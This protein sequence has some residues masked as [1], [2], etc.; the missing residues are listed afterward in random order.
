[1]VTVYS[2]VDVQIVSPSGKRMGK[3]FE[4]GGEYSE[5]PGA[6]YTGSDTEDEFVTI[7]NPEDG[8]YRVLTEGTGEGE[9]K[10]ETTEIIE[11]E[12]GVGA[13]ASTAELSGMAAPG[14]PDENKVVLSENQVVAVPKDV[15]APAIT[16]GSPEDKEYLTTES[17]P[18]SYS[19]ED[20]TTAEEDLE[21][22]A[23]LDDEPFTEDNIPANTLPAGEHVFRV[24][25]TDETGNT[26]TWETSFTVK[27]PEVTEPK[28]MPRPPMRKIV[29][30]IFSFVHEVHRNPDPPHVI[31]E[32]QKLVRFLSRWF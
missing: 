6:F 7:P 26:G 19:A 9:W 29:R 20:E 4:T 22:S 8:E 1:M 28:E 15:T 11:D 30:H 10:I 24:T 5:I 12:D 14:V 21:I 31:E 3:N 13:H 17:I 18:V 16:I 23:F 27:E 25:A 32:F 2:P